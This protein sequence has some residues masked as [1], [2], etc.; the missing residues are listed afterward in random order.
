MQLH[1]CRVVGPDRAD[2]EAVIIALHVELALR[3]ATERSLMLPRTWEAVSPAGVQLGTKLFHSRQLQQWCAGG[4]ET[5]DM[6][7]ALEAML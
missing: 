3:L 2:L 7:A 4:M 1:Q 5:P 6:I